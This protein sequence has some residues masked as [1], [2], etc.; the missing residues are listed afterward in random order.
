M[1]KK[2]L[3][4][5]AIISVTTFMFSGCNKNSDIKTE[6][7]EADWPYYETTEVLTEKC[8]DI[9]EGKVTNIFFT[10]LDITTGKISE[11]AKKENWLYTV[12]EIETTKVYKGEK[13]DRKFI[14]IIGGMSGYKE[15]E[16][17]NLIKKSTIMRNSSN[18]YIPILAGW[19]TMNKGDSYLF[20]VCD[21]G[22]DYLFI[23]SITQ[24]K[25]EIN[26]T[27]SSQGNDLP[28]YSNIKKSLIE[29]YK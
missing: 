13:T 22:G 17:F 19:K 6:Y 23:P 15:S 2:L 18:Y 7:F 26:D 21:N 9:F 20:T 29:T 4:L 25:F 11:Q 16:Q 5:I 27:L 12:Y 10:V 3:I 14:A 24:F 28:S 1:M 8:S